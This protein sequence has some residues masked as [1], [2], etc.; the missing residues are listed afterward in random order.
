MQFH[1]Q[2]RKLPVVLSVEEIAKLLASV[3][4]PGLKYRAAL[5]GISYVAGLRASDVCHLKVRDIGSHLNC[6]NWNK[7]FQPEV[8]F[9]H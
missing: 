9:L 8:S 3:P 4:G 6:F 7:K 5:C 2:P 1:W